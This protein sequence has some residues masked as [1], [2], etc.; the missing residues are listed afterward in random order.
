MPS[1]DLPTELSKPIVKF[2]P[3]ALNYLSEIAENFVFKEGSYRE[4]SSALLKLCL[5]QFVSENMQTERSTICKKVLDCV[6]KNYHIPSLTNEEIA[7]E[8]NYHPYH[9]NRI[10]KAETGKSLKNYITYYENTGFFPYFF[11]II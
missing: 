6:H 8:F 11:Y 1:Y 4:R 3:N 9:L 2:L 10:V 7:S 5:L